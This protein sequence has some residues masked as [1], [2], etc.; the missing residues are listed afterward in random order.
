MG[1]A[2][3]RE[4]TYLIPRHKDLLRDVELEKLRVHPVH[5]RRDDVVYGGCDLAD[6]FSVS[7]GEVQEVGEVRDTIL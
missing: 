7:R 5:K 2:Q 6:D 4:N 1:V 3:V